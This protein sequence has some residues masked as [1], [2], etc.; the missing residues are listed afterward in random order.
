MSAR[1]D[2]SLERRRA[3]RSRHFLCTDIYILPVPVLSKYVNEA[4]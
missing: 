3:R 4:L 2:S 1:S